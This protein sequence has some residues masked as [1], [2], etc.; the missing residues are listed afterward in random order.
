LIPTQRDVFHYITHSTISQYTPLLVSALFSHLQG[1]LKE[2][3]CCCRLEYYIYKY[4]Q[5]Q[6][7]HL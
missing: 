3:M 6:L 2:I 4:V 1:E 7:T 5:S